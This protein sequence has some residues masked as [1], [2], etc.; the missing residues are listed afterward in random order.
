MILDIVRSKVPIYVLLLWPSPKY[1]PVA[2]FGQP[3]LGTCAQN[4][5]LMTLK[6]WGTCFV[7]DSHITLF[8]SMT[9]VFELHFE[10]SAPND[11]QMTMNTTRSK[12]PHICVNRFP[13]SRFSLHFALQPARFEWQTILGQVR[14]TW[15]DLEQC[16]RGSNNYVVL[17]KKFWN[18]LIIFGK[19]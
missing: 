15:N 11:P 14:L 6:S 3:S 10:T 2:L 9:A 19:V 7:P 5:P 1:H 13:E 17:V 16:Q 18:L 4:N 8:C 12:V